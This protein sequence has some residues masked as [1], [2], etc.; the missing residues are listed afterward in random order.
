M[1]PL[2]LAVVLILAM[3]A[4]LS[5]AGCGNKVSSDSP[6]PQI[7]LVVLSDV[8]KSVKDDPRNFE[9]RGLVKTLI[10][11]YTIRSSVP[12]TIRRFAGSRLEDVLPE[13]VVGEAIEIK[14]VFDK[15]IVKFKPEDEGTH[16]VPALRDLIAYAKLHPGDIIIVLILTDGVYDDNPEE[17]EKVGREAASL[18][19]V[20]LCIA[21]VNSEWQKK[22][23]D[24]FDNAKNVHI[25]VQKDAVAALDKLTQAVKVKG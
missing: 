22:L 24:R 16:Y 12:L 25:W 2:R 1:H 3:A 19:G 21:P 11:G 20:H 17:L 13:K 15:E 10:E 18:P 6:K 7:R 23:A 8:T 9:Y 4:T 14:D 5:L